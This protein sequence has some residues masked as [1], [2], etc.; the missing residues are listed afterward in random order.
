MSRRSKE[1]GERRR[2]PVWLRIL[3]G[4]AAVLVLIAA[5]G[6]IFVLSKL[7]KINRAQ[8]VETL[9]PELE[10]FE[11]DEPETEPESA[12]ADSAE[13]ENSE[14]SDTMNPEDVIWSDAVD[15]Y[16]TDNIINVLLVGQDTTKEGGRA[17]SDAMILATVNKTDRKI[18]LTS[19]MRDMYVQ[20]PG[21][22]DNRINAAYAFGGAETLAETILVNFDVEVDGTIELDFFG[23]CDII[24]FIGGIDMEVTE[25]EIPVMNDYIRGLNGLFGR[26]RETDIVTEPGYL[27]LNG[28]QALGYSRV[29]YVGNGDFAR[30]QRQRKVMMAAF[31]KVKDLSITE[32]LS[33]ADQVLPLVTTD[34][35]NLELIS[36]AASI[37]LMDIEEIETH[38]IPEDAAYQSARIRGM[39]VLVP[40]LDECRR[41]LQ[42]IIYG[43][44]QEI[45]E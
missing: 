27:H 1:S 6:G 19:L 22:S 5:A 43:S 17:R 21:Y 30:T 40:D 44:G 37:L 2:M 26:D 3:L 25:A 20:I 14:D 28:I 34:L 10:Y 32:M 7:G 12:E 45:E 13:T 11:T 8:P 4:T 35:S 9:A 41:T 31:E 29:R 33:F 42:E 16:G 36:L 24:D 15:V 39:A 18:I 23:F 38:N